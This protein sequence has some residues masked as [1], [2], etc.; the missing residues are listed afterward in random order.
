MAIIRKLREIL[1][2]SE[3]ATSLSITPEGEEE[4]SKGAV[5]VLNRNLYLCEGALPARIYI[6]TYMYIHAI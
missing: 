1:I 5:L 4:G 2:K 3:H 6:Y